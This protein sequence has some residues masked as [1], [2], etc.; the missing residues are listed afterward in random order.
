MKAGEHPEERSAFPK[1]RS[2]PQP[3]QCALWKA[4]TLTSE[5]LYRS[6]ELVEWFTQQKHFERALV[7]CKQCGLLYFHETYEYWDGDDDWDYLTY[8][9][10]SNIEQVAELRETD[11]YSL[12]RF[13]PRLQRDSR[14]DNKRPWVFWVRGNEPKVG[15]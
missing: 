7:R 4:E 1:H 3:T 8:I 12:L 13:S 6:F 15:S 5:G 10:V 2:L 14:P 11:Q 9:P